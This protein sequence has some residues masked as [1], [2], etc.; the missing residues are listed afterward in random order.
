MMNFGEALASL[1]EGKAVKRVGWNGKEQFIELGTHI[2]FERPDGTRVMSG[3][4]NMGSNA[5][6]FFGTSGTQVGWLASQ[7][8]MLAED[9]ILVDKEN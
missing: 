2:S 6:V 3:H 8:D 9:W 5:I 1:K 4:N 7:A